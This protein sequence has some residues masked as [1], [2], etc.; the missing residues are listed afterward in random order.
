[1]ATHPATEAAVERSIRALV[2][3]HQRIVW[4]LLR[5]LACLRRTRKTQLNRYS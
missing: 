4:R 3:A 2:A 1:M 5:G